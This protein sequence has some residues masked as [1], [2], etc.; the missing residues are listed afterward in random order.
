MFKLIQDE[1]KE[2]DRLKE[3]KAFDLVR[4]ILRREFAKQHHFLE[5]TPEVHST[6][7]TQGRCQ[8]IRELMDLF[9]KEKAEI[10]KI[11][12][13]YKEP[14]VKAKHKFYFIIKF[15]ELFKKPIGHLIRG[16]V[17]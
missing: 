12:L 13:E 2:L 3:H 4:E 1:Q 15:L 9:S 11:S 16:P 6:F 10:Q 17:K 8:T 14:P 5:S 7:V